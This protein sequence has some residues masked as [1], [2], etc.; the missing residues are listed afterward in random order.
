MA[1]ERARTLRQQP[2]DA[3]RRLWS[4]LRNRQLSGHKFRRQASIGRYIADFVCFESKLVVEVDGGQH[5][6]SRD[7]AK[8][9][10]WLESQGFRV[11]RFWNNDVLENIDGVAQSI[12]A[13]LAE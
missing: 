1:D 7:D 13:A 5:A 4:I 3:E 2:T 12:R 9:T 10:A 11:V 8:R 6:N